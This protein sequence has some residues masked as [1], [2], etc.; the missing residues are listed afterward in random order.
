MNW[1]TCQHN[2]AISG[3]SSQRLLAS[4][5]ARRNQWIIASLDISMAFLRGLTYQELAEATG[6]EERVACFALPPSISAQISPRIR[7]LS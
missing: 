4:A 2:A 7:A 6:E 1:Q 5:A 3:G